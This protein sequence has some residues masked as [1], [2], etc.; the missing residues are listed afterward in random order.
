MIPLDVLVV[1]DERAIGD[2][3]V[4]DKIVNKSGQQ[5]GNKIQNLRTFHI[6]STS[7]Y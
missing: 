3:E 1:D 6:K 7:M 2:E 4:T 5:N